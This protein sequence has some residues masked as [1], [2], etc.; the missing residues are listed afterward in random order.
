MVTIFPP[1]K[2]KLKPERK[3]STGRL[4]FGRYAKGT[5]RAKEFRPCTR[6]GWGCPEKLG[7]TGSP[8]WTLTKVK[9]DCVP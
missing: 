8:G 2:L 3:L 4:G 1:W 5:E 7:D 6:R 9:K